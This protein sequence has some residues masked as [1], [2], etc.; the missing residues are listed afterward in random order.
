MNDE[1]T[2]LSPD[3]KRFF[4]ATKRSGNVRSI[5]DPKDYAESFINNWGYRRL[6]FLCKYHLNVLGLRLMTKN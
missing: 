6:D 1:R 2:F 3:V 4:D 5:M